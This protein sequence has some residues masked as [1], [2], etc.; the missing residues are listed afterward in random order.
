M[1]TITMKILK[2]SISAPNDSEALLNSTSP[3]ESNTYLRFKKG[4]K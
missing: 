3:S 2:R 4:C 1:R